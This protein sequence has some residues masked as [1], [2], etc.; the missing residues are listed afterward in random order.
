MFITVKLKEMNFNKLNIERVWDR[1]KTKMRI[2]ISKKCTLG[3]YQK[4]IMI[5]LTR[6]LVLFQWQHSSHAPQLLAGR[7]GPLRWWHHGWTCPLS[8]RRRPGCV[9]GWHHGWSEESSLGPY[10]DMSS[11][12]HARD[13]EPRGRAVLHQEAKVNNSNLH[14]NTQY[15]PKHSI[16]LIIWISFCREGAA[17]FTYKRPRM[18]A[19]DLPAGQSNSNPSSRGQEQ[20]S[21]PLPSSSSRAETGKIWDKTFS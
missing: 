2:A 16:L 21:G 18:L 17:V 4:I 5:N 7:G 12:L 14:Y 10:E 8:V 1:R 11:S 3:W 13:P 20:S 19:T 15:L 9:L 6:I